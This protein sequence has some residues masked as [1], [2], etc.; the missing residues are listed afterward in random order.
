MSP[1]PIERDCRTIGNHDG[2]WKTS[3]NLKYNWSMDKTFDLFFRRQSVGQNKV[4][5]GDGTYFYTEDNAAK[6]RY[7]VLN[8]MWWSYKENADGTS[9]KTTNGFGADQ[10]NW[11]IN[12]AL[13]FEDEGWT[14]V[15]ISHAP[16]TNEEHSYLRD[17]SVVQGILTAHAEK[18]TFTSEA[19]TDSSNAGHNVPGVTV[20]YTNKNTAK[21]AGWFSGHIHGNSIVKLD[22][23]AT[24]PIYVIRISSDLGTDYN[25]TSPVGTLGTNTEHAIDFVTIDTEQELV[26]LTRLGGG[27]NRYY[28]YG[29]TEIVEYTV[30]KNLTD[31]SISNTADKVV[32]GS[33]YAAIITAN[34]G[35]TLD[36]VTVTMGGAPVTVS[37][38][39]INIASV[40]GD[41][42]ITATATEQ[43]VEPSYTNLFDAS[44]ATI[45]ARVSSSGAVSTGT[46]GY[47][48]SDLI[49]IP[50]S[51][52]GDGT[53]IIRVYNPNCTT[54]NYNTHANQKA[55]YYNNG[56]WKVSVILSGD[57]TANTTT[58]TLDDNNIASFR[59]AVKNNAVVSD[60][61]NATHIRI[62]LAYTDSLT[63]ITSTDQL[64]GVIITINEPIS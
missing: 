34:E 3:A 7:V 10:I 64:S 25:E 35:Y 61:A 62:A 18:T 32:S 63:T 46:D 42:V 16:L 24:V 56:T 4:F 59:G 5:G 19:F 21:I 28:S 2:M 52:K 38:G 20:D 37:G 57:D 23:T 22:D 51:W 27:E 39:S 43:V 29:E 14:L 44:K 6:V 49:P 55:C 36:G 12:K 40:T 60:A 30:T 41:I 50:D 1:I 33:A 58:V 47:F 31:C 11:L 9:T 15:F 26:Y 53:D 48:V 45:N 17:V 8:S 54:Y 13:V